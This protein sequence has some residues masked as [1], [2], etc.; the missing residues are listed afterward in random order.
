M[1]SPLSSFSINVP[2][3]KTPITPGNICPQSKC[4]EAN[5]SQKSESLEWKKENGKEENIVE[6]TSTL[7]YTC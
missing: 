1:L 3:I 5:V 2:P 7:E 4:T 6:A